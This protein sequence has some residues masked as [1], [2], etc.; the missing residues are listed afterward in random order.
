[1]KATQFLVLEKVLFIGGGAEKLEE[2]VKLMIEVR[3]LPYG[4]AMVVEVKRLLNKAL[5]RG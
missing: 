4:F 5:C 2:R 3:F 1:M